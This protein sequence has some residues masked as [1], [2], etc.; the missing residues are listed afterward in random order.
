MRKLVFQSDFGLCDGA[1]SAMK[2]TAYKVHGD[3]VLSDVTHDIT[4]FNIWEASY[5]LFQVFDFWPDGTVFVSVVDPGVG[6]DRKSVVARLRNDKM[7][8]TPDNGTLSHLALHGKILELREIDESVNRLT[9]SEGS[10]TFH[11]R[12]VYAY[13]GARLACD[14]IQYDGV[15]GELNPDNVVCI[16]KSDVVFKNETLVGTVEILDKR[17]GHLW[18]DISE[19]DLEKL[20]V[21]YGDSLNVRIS[22]DGKDHYNGVVPFCKSFFDVE[23]G[24]KLT[25]INSMMGLAIAIHT[26]SF[27]K[28]YGIESGPGW[29]IEISKVKD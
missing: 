21:S 20:N 24:E 22:Y 11:G 23:T 8:V 18:T 25:Y 26:E 4:P 6:S 2:A 16:S 7:I 15:G 5:R 13:T 29:G 27:S 10:H 3:L 12:D 28:E 17:F 14:A 9:G 1:V 19:N